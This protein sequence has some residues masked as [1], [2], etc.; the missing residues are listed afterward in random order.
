MMAQESFQNSKVILDS[1]VD[2]PSPNKSPDVQE[3]QI[4]DDIKKWDEI[5][6]K[7]AADS[8]DLKSKRED[9]PSDLSELEKNSKEYTFKPRINQP[10]PEKAEELTTPDAVMKEFEAIKEQYRQRRIDNPDV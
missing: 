7:K 6:R 1:S 9:K 3:S 10:K 8:P 2:G 5:Y 4:S